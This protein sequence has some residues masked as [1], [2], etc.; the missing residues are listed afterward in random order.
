MALTRLLPILWPLADTTSHASQVASAY[1]AV[2]REAL[3]AALEACKVS[4]AAE[5]HRVEGGVAGGDFPA[6][7]AAAG[8]GDVGSPAAGSA[9]GE[10]LELLL[11]ALRAVW[12]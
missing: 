8:N 11:S 9:L 5:R 4:H 1:P 12:A 10:K 7:Q 6:V 2:Q 3:L